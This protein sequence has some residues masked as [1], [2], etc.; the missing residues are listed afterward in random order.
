[1]PDRSRAP[2]P[3][4]TP[5]E[6]RNQAAWNAD[7]DDYQQRHGAQLADSAGLAWG[8][9]QVPEAE[10]QVLGDVAGR[11]VLALAAGRRSGRSGWHG[12]ARDRSGSTFP[13][14]SWSTPAG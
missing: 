8:T 6:E 1:M 12:A 7:S 10:L 4:L 14:A 3:A 5:H 13:S 9:Y 2:D 11:D